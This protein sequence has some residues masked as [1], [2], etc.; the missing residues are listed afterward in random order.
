MATGP[1]KR[2]F[3]GQFKAIQGNS[4][5]KAPTIWQFRGN[6]SAKVMKHKNIEIAKD[7]KQNISQCPLL[8]RLLI[9]ILIRKQ[10]GGKANQ[11]NEEQKLHARNTRD[12]SRTLQGGWAGGPRGRGEYMLDGV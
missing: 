1:A 9:I 11:N 2:Q 3:R 6:S 5:A 7:F 4:D 10:R 8:G 12:A